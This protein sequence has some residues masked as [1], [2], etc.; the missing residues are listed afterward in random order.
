[1]PQS[2]KAFKFPPFKPTGTGIRIDLDKLYV[3]EDHH[4]LTFRDGTNWPLADDLQASQAFAG[5]IRE[6]K[7]ALR[8]RKRRS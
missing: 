3:Y 1:M 4:N 5:L 7:K 8:E 6:A 2:G